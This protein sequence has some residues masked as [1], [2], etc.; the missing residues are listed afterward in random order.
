MEKNTKT[1]TLELSINFMKGFEI[2][3]ECVCVLMFLSLGCNLVMCYELQKINGKFSC[4]FSKYR[5][6]RRG[7][8]HG[9]IIIYKI[10]LI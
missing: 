7:N 8:Q 5:P 2:S 10:C 9:G 1:K 3:T 4:F 6:V